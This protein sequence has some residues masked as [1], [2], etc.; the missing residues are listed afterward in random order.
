MSNLSLSLF[1]DTKLY[2]KYIEYLKDVRKLKPSTI[3]NFLTVA[4]N[5]VKY[6]KKMHDGAVDIEC[7]HEIQAY[8][9]LMHQF[10]KENSENAFERFQQKVF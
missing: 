7:A 6:T 5:V 2:T 4:I 1:N 10:S 8:R 9:S 3:V